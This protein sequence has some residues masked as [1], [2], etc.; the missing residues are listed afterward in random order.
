MLELKKLGWIRS[1]HFDYQNVK[2]KFRHYRELRKLPLYDYP[3]EDLARRYKNKKY[4]C[5]TLTFH[6]LVAISTFAYIF[7]E[8]EAVSVINI[9]IV[10]VLM[11]VITGENI[12]MYILSNF[13]CLKRNNDLY[14]ENMRILININ[15]GVEKINAKD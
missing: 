7:Y 4:W 2:T 13:M 1:I 12:E 6:L 14:A 11:I 3:Y 15:E 9:F 5:I 10:L 8:L